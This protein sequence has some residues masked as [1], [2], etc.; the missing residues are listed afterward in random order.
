MSSQNFI[1]IVGNHF[2]INSDVGLEPWDG[3][4]LLVEGN[5]FCGMRNLVNAHAT[6]GLVY[7]VSTPE[8]AARC[9]AVFGEAC[10]P[11]A[12]H[13]TKPVP[14]CDRNVLQQAL[15]TDLCPEAV[16]DARRAVCMPVPDADELV[17]SFD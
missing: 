13:D 2:D 9:E 8:Q 5:R 7:L 6:K 12:Y 16:N 14:R 11:N 15:S 1:H 10:L 3:A 4:F 17:Q